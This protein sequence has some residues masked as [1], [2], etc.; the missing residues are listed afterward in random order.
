MAILSIAQLILLFDVERVNDLASDYDSGAKKPVYD[1]D[2]L[3]AII[4]Q[5]TDYVEAQLSLQYTTAELEADKSIER[6][7]ADIAMYFLES[8]RNQ[9]SPAVKESF[10]RAQNYILGLLEGTFKLAAVSQ[11]LPQGVETNSLEVL[12]SA[13]GFL[14]LTEDEQDILSGA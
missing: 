11:L 1:A 12:D 5:A 10:E 9:V 7:A 14:Y 13:E 4:A 6:V 8:R 2:I 3:T